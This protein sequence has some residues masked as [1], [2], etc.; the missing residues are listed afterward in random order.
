MKPRR[1]RKRKNS[2]K[3]L[4]FRRK[5]HS[6]GNVNLGLATAAL[7]GSSSRKIL[8]HSS[9]SNAARGHEEGTDMPDHEGRG[10]SAM[11]LEMRDER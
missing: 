6:A 2:L 7:P 11:A 1:T 9:S 4:T 8:A 10:R 5:R 3:N